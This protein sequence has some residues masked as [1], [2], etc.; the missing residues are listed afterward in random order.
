M[1]GSARRLDRSLLV[2]AAGVSAAIHVAKLPPALPA[3]QASLGLGLVQAGF[4]ISLV[5]LAGLS[6]GLAVGLAA[7]SLGLRRTLLVG[8]V[9][10]S[11]VSL[12]SGFAHSVGVLLALRA[13]EGL[14]FLL[15]VMPAPGLIRRLVSPDRLSVRLGMWGTYMPVGTALAL[16]AG[17]VWIAAAGWPAWWWLAGALSAAMAVAVWRVLPADPPAA[18]RR[19]GAPADGWRA[20]L[21]D[22]LRARG[23]WLVALAFAVYSSQWIAVVGFLPTLYAEA[24]LAPAA[25]GVAT[26]LAAGVNMLGNLASGRLLHGGHRPEQLLQA[27]FAA[28][29][30]GGVLAFAPVWPAVAGLD[31]V[32]PY[33]AVLVFSAVGGLVPGT[34]FS[35]A[36]RLAPHAGAVSTTVGWMQQWSAFGQFAGPP[37]VAWV[38]SRTGGWA[39]S[40][41]V[42]VACACAG[43]LLARRIGTLRRS[44]AAVAA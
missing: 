19:G 10:L 15:A 11:G 43:L 25:A 36:V 2:I 28:M 27:G 34:L 6:L 38:A 23:P 17:P 22:T 14:G 3:L 32:G 7:D 20:R 33:L 30:A 9:L 29:A 39:W 42:T 35:L 31:V 1:S 21:A 13:L 40:W 16:L 37:V 18:A 24:G 8:L 41:V 26:A 44:L 12:A 4:L 5:Q